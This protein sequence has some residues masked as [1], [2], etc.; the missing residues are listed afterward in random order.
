MDAV[1]AI[2]T[3]GLLG[4]LVLGGFHFGRAERIAAEFADYRAKVVDQQRQDQ[5]RAITQGLKVRK[6]QQEAVDAEHIAR[7]A[8]EA[9]ARRA[10][11]AHERLQ[12]DL[13]S[14][15]V[16]FSAPGPVASGE[17]E[18]AR[19]TSAML[20]DLLGRCSERRRELAQFADESHGAGQLCESIYGALSPPP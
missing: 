17:C 11:L 8:A 5:E 9:D 10:V 16:R 12:Y 4:A 2:L 15:G 18:A 13:R 1:R 3:A 19:E 7:M 20:A 6:V 14:A